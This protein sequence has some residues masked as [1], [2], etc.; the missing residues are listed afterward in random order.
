MHVVGGYW[1]GSRDRSYTAGSEVTDMVDLGA[2]W[3]SGGDWNSGS[4]ISSTPP[5]SSGEVEDML[6]LEG[7]WNSGSDSSCTPPLSRSD[8]D[9][10]TLE[11]GEQGAENNAQ[12]DDPVA[13]HAHSVNELKRKAPQ[14]QPLPNAAKKGRMA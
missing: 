4:D 9:G 14:L 7:Y 11:N 2:D 8:L 13:A 10:I 12:R 5:L 3:N 6:S 1:N